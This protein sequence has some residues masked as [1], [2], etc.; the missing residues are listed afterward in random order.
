[1]TPELSYEDKMIP[2]KADLAP[3]MGGHYVAR[4]GEVA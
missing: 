3:M 2:A 4:A 1:M